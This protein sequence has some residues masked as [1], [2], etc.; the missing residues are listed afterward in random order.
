M[1]KN[2]NVVG[3]EDTALFKADICK[4]GDHYFRFI[5]NTGMTSYFIKNYDQLKG[6]TDGHT[7]YKAT[8]RTKDRFINSVNLVK[9]VMETKKSF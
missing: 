8:K 1:E 3:N 2:T 4:I 6:K 5:E 7:Y 9:E